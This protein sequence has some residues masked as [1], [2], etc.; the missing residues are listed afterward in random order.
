MTQCHN[1]VLLFH[2]Q[3][4]DMK[5]RDRVVVGEIIPTRWLKVVLRKCRSKRGLRH[6]HC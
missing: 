6:A 3:F 1:E 2:T 5:R 4:S